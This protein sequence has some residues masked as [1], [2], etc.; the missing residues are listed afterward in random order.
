[1]KTRNA[2]TALL[3]ML[4][5]ASTALSGCS[6]GD[7]SASHPTAT[8]PIRVDSLHV[9]RTSD[10]PRADLQPLDITETD[11]T[12]VQAL[13]DGLISLPKYIPSGTQCPVDTGVQ[14]E[15]TFA[16][17]STTVLQAIADP[18]GCQI[19]VLNG[20]DNRIANDSL[21][22]LLASSLGKPTSA[23]YPVPAS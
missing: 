5:L 11:G 1:M 19:V 8:T 6:G 12:K 21:W 15:L 17:A 18:S 7:T 14:Y 23:I 2:L 22:S 9:T 3:L 4:M 20:K 16:S 10:V 13:Y